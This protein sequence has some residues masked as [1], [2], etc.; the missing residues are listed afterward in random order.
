MGLEPAGD[1][2]GSMGAPGVLGYN[3]ARIS[4]VITSAGENYKY[5]YELKL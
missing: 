2:A 5:G 1:V 3:L 4:W